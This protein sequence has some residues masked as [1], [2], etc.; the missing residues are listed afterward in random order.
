MFFQASFT[1]L[2]LPNRIEFPKET[3]QA[4]N[5]KTA[6]SLYNMQARIVNTLKN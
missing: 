1:S 4:N 5:H 3:L 6:S 2:S